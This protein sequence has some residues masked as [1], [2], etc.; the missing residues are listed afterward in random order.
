M[1]IGVAEGSVWTE[2][3]CGLAWMPGQPVSRRL[4]RLDDVSV[5]RQWSSGGKR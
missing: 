1:F 3:W 4:E 5:S 2:A